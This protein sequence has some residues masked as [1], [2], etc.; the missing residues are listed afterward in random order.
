MAQINYSTE[1]PERIDSWIKFYDILKG[2]YNRE[3][4]SIGKDDTVLFRGYKGEEIR[5]EVNFIFSK[6][7]EEFDANR[8]TRNLVYTIQRALTMNPANAKGIDD[9]VVKLYNIC[10]ND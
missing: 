9:A 7:I 2:I 10:K 6:V 1:L 4:R 8:P 3:E 5:Y